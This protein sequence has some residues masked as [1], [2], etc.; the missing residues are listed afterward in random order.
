MTEGEFSGRANGCELTI[1]PF[2]PAPPTLLS[3][4]P[5]PH[6]TYVFRAGKTVDHAT[7]LS[8]SE[9]TADIFFPTNFSVLARMVDDERRRDSARGTD[10]GAPA[11]VLAS[12]EFLLTYGAAQVQR[13]RTMTGYNPMLEDFTNTRFLLT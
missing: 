7:Y 13:T 6:H 4:S 2:F 12:S 8:P 11:R 5:C 10:V 9:G 3:P 1:L